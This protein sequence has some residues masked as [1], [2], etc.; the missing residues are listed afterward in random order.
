MASDIVEDFLTVQ[1]QHTKTTNTRTFL[2]G[3]RKIAGKKDSIAKSVL[4]T[5]VAPQRRQIDEAAILA[6]LDFRSLPPKFQQ[7]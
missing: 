3:L 7:F 1:E 6:E 4:I 5:F 2:Q